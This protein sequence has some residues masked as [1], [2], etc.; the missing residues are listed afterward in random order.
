[1]MIESLEEKF[2]YVIL[3]VFKLFLVLYILL[4]DINIFFII[5]NSCIY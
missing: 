2:V 5:S 4:E 1:M 3:F